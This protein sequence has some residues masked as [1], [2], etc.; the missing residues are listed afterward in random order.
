MKNEHEIL[1][2]IKENPVAVVST[3]GKDHELYGAAVYVCA[4]T[5]SQLYFVTKSETQKL[6]NI[7]E[8]PQIAVT[9]VNTRDN[10]SLQ[11]RGRAQI[12]ED[13]AVIDLVMSKM[14]A[15]YA[16]GADWLPPIAKI[17]A[18]AYQIVS[19]TLHEA[20][21]AHYKNFKPGDT[22]IFT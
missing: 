15:I 5:A 9:I 4:L 12:L 13:A 22:R 10:S 3:L 18:G 21:M 20:R 17:R 16:N 11:A 1:S 7:Q 8:H 19:I 6:Q 2:Y 14:A